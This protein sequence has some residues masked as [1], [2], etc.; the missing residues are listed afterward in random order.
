MGRTSVELE[1]RFR[2]IYRRGWSRTLA[3]TV[4]WSRLRP[5]LPFEALICGLMRPP[6]QKSVV[7]SSELSVG[8]T[9]S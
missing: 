9:D 1:K 6:G 4:V 3:G 2:A 8:Q 5:E 7:A